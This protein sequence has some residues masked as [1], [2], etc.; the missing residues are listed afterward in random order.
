MTCPLCARNGEQVVW[1]DAHCRVIQVADGEHPGL[2]R[3]IWHEHVAEMTD[4]LA[5]DRHHLFEVVLATELA[6]R[7]LLHP[8]KINL[9]SL[10]NVVPHMHWHV[11]PRYSDDIHFPLS[12]W[13]PAGAG[14]E[15]HP[16]ADP[17]ALSRAIDDALASLQHAES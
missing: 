1:E 11:I 15:L 8:D 17:V 3:V 7:N 9:A 5:A 6:L 14:K 4:L 13:G 16:A 2:C 10:G 12:I